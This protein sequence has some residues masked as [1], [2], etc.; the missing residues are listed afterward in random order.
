MIERLDSLFRLTA[1]TNP[2]ERRIARNTTLAA[3]VNL[4]FVT[5]AIVALAFVNVET[6]L[7]ITYLILLSNALGA[8]V[9]I[10]LVQRFYTQLGALLLIGLLGAGATAVVFAPGASFYQATLSWTLTIFVAALVAHRRLV[11]GVGVIAISVV[12]LS[13]VVNEPPAADAIFS[14]AQVVLAMAI[15]QIIT[16]DFEAIAEQTEKQ[17]GLRRLQLIEI[18]SAVYGRISSRLELELLLKETVDII[19]DGFEEIYH[20]Q[21]FL[22]DNQRQFAVL[23]AST[24]EVGRQ[25]IDR[26]H[27]LAIGTQSVIGQVTEKGTYV[28][29]SDTSVDPMHKRNELLPETRTELALPLRVKEGVIGALDLQSRTPNAFIPE[30]IEIFQTLADQIAVAIENAR[31][32]NQV[33]SQ[34]NDNLRL[35][36]Q[37]QEN[38]QQIERLN[39]EL[40]HTAW[41]DYVMTS[42]TIPHLAIDL[43]TQTITPQVAVSAISEKTFTSVEVQVETLSNKTIVTLP[44][45]VQGTAVGVLE[46]EI[47]EATT[48][49]ETTSDALATIGERVGLIAENVRLFETTQ[50]VAASR[51]QLSQITSQMQGLTTVETLLRLAVTELGQAIGAQTGFI[52]LMPAS[53]QEEWVEI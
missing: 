33:Q 10:A 28:L 47:P 3:V 30:D 44:V 40:T 11:L 19:R 38:R 25:L 22:I 24:G 14:L 29:A 45:K 52:R 2:L 23:R 12:I 20:A 41:R 4:I 51:E 48:V 49:S 26:R 15:A 27:A 8:L 18:S 31:L 13:W 21:V 39:R 16:R 17:V 43:A 35:L 37:E 50:R 7:G 53:E 46:F 9:V 32:L 1:Y 42:M 36:Q 5:I 34:A 6:D